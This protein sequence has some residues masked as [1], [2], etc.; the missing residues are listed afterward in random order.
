MKQRY[1][2]QEVGFDIWVEAVNGGFIG[3]IEGPHHRF[4]PTRECFE[5]EEAALA[6]AQHLCFE[7]VCIYHERTLK[8]A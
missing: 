1:H 3:W 7:H 5:T 4:A 8:T 2:V 6:G